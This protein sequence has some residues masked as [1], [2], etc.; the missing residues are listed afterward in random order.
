MV[1]LAFVTP[2]TIVEGAKRDT[3]RCQR[4]LA[5]RQPTQPGS[6]G[7]GGLRWL[8]PGDRGQG[9][10]VLCGL[11]FAGSRET[12]V[13]LSQGLLGWGVRF[14]FSWEPGE[15]WHWGVCPRGAGQHNMRQASWGLA[16]NQQRRVGGVDWDVRCA[17]KQHK[18]QRNNNSL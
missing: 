3:G 18:Y 8:I 15:P 13:L 1:R 6:R 17:T 14:F 2:L 12:S 16:I 11:P 7:R 10:E 9:E 5:S 4:N